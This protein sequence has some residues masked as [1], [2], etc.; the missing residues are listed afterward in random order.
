MEQPD[1]KELENKVERLCDRLRNSKLLT[2]PP[3]CTYVC[4]YTS[5]GRSRETFYRLEI[6]TIASND[7]ME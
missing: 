6:V 3:L 4:M 5:L 7:V 1:S 2:D